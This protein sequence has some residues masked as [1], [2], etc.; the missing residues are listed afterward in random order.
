MN[1]ITVNV[2]PFSFFSWAFVA[3]YKVMLYGI[4]LW[5][6]WI[7]CPG[8]ASSQPLVRPQPSHWSVVM[9]V[10]RWC[11]ASTLQQWPKHWCII[12]TV[13]ATDP[14]HNTVRASM[15]KVNSILDRPSTLVSEVG[16]CQNIFLSVLQINILCQVSKELP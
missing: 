6:I 12:N 1:V 8:F 5:L 13:L 11:Y 3:E 7:S 15:K 10:E 14:K 2:L 4:S 16:T 9:V